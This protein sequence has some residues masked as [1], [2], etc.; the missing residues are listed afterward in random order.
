MPGFELSG[1]SRAPV[2]EVWKLLYDPSR[3][4]EWWAGVET[5][6]SPATEPDEYVLWPTGY[7][8]FPMPQR[9]RGSRAEGRVTISCQI[10]DL[11]FSWQLTPDGDGTLIQVTVALPEREAHRL[12]GQREVITT[13]LGRLAQL[14]QVEAG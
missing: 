9:L 11:E 14:A 1:R 6:Q 13:S 2:E 5:V 12:T 10:S 4:P 3:F 8:D 7:P